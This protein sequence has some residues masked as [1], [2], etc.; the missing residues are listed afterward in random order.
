MLIS[1]HILLLLR[2]RHYFERSKLNWI[3]D[4]LHNILTKPLNTNSRITDDFRR[5]DYGSR[6]LIWQN[7]ISDQRQLLTYLFS[8]SRKYFL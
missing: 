5:L 3:S 2:S 4:R 8:L 1:K 6:V 7:E